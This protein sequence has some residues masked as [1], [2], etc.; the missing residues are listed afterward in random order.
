MTCIL[1]IAKRVKKKLTSPS[2]FPRKHDDLRKFLTITNKSEDLIREIKGKKGKDFSLIFQIGTDKEL[3]ESDIIS[4]AIDLSESGFQFEI[5]RF[6]AER[7]E[8]GILAVLLS[9]HIPLPYLQTQL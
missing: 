2:L 5:K 6:Q 7:S 3:E 4:V 9:S 1:P 8:E